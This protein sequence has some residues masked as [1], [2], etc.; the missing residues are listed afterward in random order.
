VFDLPIEGAAGSLTLLDE[1]VARYHEAEKTAVAR[2]A[3]S[4]HFPQPFQAE[5]SVP[6]RD[7]RAST[8]RVVAM[9]RWKFYRAKLEAYQVNG[10]Y[11]F[12]HADFKGEIA[13]P[14][15][16]RLGVEP[17]PGWE[18]IDAPPA[19]KSNLIMLFLYHG[20]AK[21]ALVE[22]VGTK[23]LASNGKTQRIV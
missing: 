7:D 1:I 8:L 11:E 3:S 6:L 18:R 17:G 10:S 16:D 14:Y 20:N 23:S 9:G 12:T 4:D 22:M 19:A 5:V 21:E 15:V 13:T 2:A